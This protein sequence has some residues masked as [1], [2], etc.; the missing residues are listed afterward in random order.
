[1]AINEANDKAMEIKADANVIF[2]DEEELYIQA[3]GL[4][5]YLFTL[6]R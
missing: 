3:A 2:N 5:N 1:M 6:T 4:Q